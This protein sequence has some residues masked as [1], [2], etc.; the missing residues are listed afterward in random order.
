[1]AVILIRWG[2]FDLD[3]GRKKGLGQSLA[4]PQT[5]YPNQTD[6]K[7]YINETRSLA[8]CSISVGFL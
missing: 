1:M 7:T 5:R 3:Y 8:I 6:M 2:W 4:K